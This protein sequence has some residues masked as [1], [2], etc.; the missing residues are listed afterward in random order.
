MAEL[1]CYASLEAMDEAS[2]IAEPPSNALGSL[3]MLTSPLLSPLGALSLRG[4][5]LEPITAQR[6]DPHQTV[7]H[8]P[9]G[10]IL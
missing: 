2:H 5:A 8:G 6:P 10:G 9:P 3:G 7:E 1:G 4:P